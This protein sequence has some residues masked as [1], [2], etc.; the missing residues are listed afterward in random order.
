MRVEVDL[1]VFW[2]LVRVV[3]PGEVLD[4]A[5][6]GLLVQ[7]L[8]ISL[9]GNSKRHVDIDL[10]EGKVGL[11]VELSGSVS[12]LLVWG[13]E[14]RQGDDAGVGKELRHLGDSS[15]V[16][17]SVLLA[18]AQVLVQAESDVVTVESVAL[19]VVLEQFSLERTSNSALSGGTQT[20][21]PE[22]GPVLLDELFAF[23]MG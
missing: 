5:L 16:L 2:S 9:F 6:S 3:D 11:L 22:G 8:W 4:K 18:E 15:D 17:V 10:D 12:V 1:W 14:G 13:D 21:E 20:C 19:D 7:A 23:V